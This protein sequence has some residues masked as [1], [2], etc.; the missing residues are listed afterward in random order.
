[1]TVNSAD[2]YI[3]NVKVSFFFV[4]P[5]TCS[6]E[7]FPCDQRARILPLQAETASLYIP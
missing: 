3:L 1:M 5:S 6:W 2:L 7:A 4:F